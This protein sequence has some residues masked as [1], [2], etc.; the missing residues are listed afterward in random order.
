MKYLN[1]SNDCGIANIVYHMPIFD[2]E[3]E[4]FSES[5]FDDLGNQIENEEAGDKKSSD[6]SLATATINDD[7]NN[8]NQSKL[9]NGQPQQSTSSDE[10]EE[11]NEDDFISKRRLRPNRRR[12]TIHSISTSQA[13]QIGFLLLLNETGMIINHK[14]PELNNFEC[15]IAITPQSDNDQ[16][17]IVDFITCEPTFFA[18]P[19][20]RSRRFYITKDN[21]GWIVSLSAF[22]FYATPGQTTETGY[23]HMRSPSHFTSGYGARSNQIKKLYNRSESG[24]NTILV[25]CLS[26]GIKQS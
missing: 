9:L 6:E 4:G 10:K 19:N 2:D 14:S 1:S 11:Q 3:A 12:G 16:N 5:F 26:C 13:N 25:G 20:T 7:N 24:R 22:L 21:I 23:T 18:I 15:V 17:Y 8:E